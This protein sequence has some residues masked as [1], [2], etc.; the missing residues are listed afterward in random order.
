[1]RKVSFIITLFLTIIMNIQAQNTTPLTPETLW[2]MG[3]VS[4]QCLTPDATKALYSV[5]RY[6]IDENKGTST[7]YAVN[8]DGSSVVEIATGATA[9]GFTSEGRLLYIKGGKFYTIGIDGK[10]SREAGT[11]SQ[12][13]TGARLS[14]QGDRIVFT[15]EV[16]YRKTPAEIYPQYTKA[17]VVITDDLMYRHW[18]YW[19]DDK[20][21]HV[22][23]VDFDG[24]KTVGEAV[25]IMKGEPYD[26]PL[27]PFGGMEQINFSRDGKQIAYTCKKKEGTAYATSTDSDIYIYDIESATTRNLTEGNHGYDTCPVWSPCG[28]YIAWSSMDEDGYEAD[29][30]D[31]KVYDIA[32][33]KTYNLTSEWDET[34]EEF[35]WVTSG[36][37][38][39]RTAV[40]AVEQLFTYTLPKKLA[41]IDVTK[42]IKQITHLNDECIGSFIPAGKKVIVTRYGFNR[43][44]E[45]FSYDVKK[46]SYTAITHENDEIFATIPSVKVEKRWVPTT[47]GKKMLVWVLLPPSFDSTQKYPAMLFC[48][49]GPQNAI[50]PSYSF[51]CNFALMAHEGYVTIIPNRRGLP[52]FGVEWN[53]EISTQ[54]G[55]QA[56][57]DLMTASDA[58]V[59]EP[60]VDEKRVA[61]VGAS[62]GGYS[63]FMLAGKHQGR[64]SAFISHCGTFD[65]RSW[66]MTTEELFFAHKDM[67]CAPWENPTHPSYT[68]YS[69][70]SHVDKWDTPILIIQGAQDYRVPEGQSMQAFTAARMR[71]IPSRYVL[72]PEECH[73]VLRPQNSLVW[74]AEFYS[75]LDKYLK[76]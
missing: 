3:R 71:G 1:M 10:D 41:D 28:K 51:R 20:V 9:V 30:N 23:Y 53:R 49:G 17:N 46:D 31:I 68:E 24:E 26:A 25:D 60:Y 44:A 14:P 48:G 12:E 54:W 52:S 5:T 13:V 55:A 32:A 37:I 27:M 56:I 45:V 73:W 59:K 57:T 35:T 69:P 34:I 6:N 75:W 64:Y 11:L 29:K 58:V 19:E 18:N 4:L 76:K 15:A 72:F 22:F 42:S 50:C 39:F 2:K 36:E 43:P 70:V 62:Y 21:S 16:K 33:G 38:M 66:Y 7:L 61:A 67:G 8:V 40:E 47:D 63:V 65:T 74:H